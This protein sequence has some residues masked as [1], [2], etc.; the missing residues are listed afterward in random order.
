MPNKPVSQRQI[1]TRAGNKSSHPGDVLKPPKRRNTTEVEAERA[2]KAQAKKDRELARR[3]GIERTARFERDDLVRENEIDATPRPAPKQKALPRT[4]SLSSEADDAEAT[5]DGEA[6][7]K[8]SNVD[9]TISVDDSSVESGSPPPVKKVRAGSVTKGKAKATKK[10]MGKAA[11]KKVI[12]D[13][14]GRVVGPET[15]PPKPKKSLREEI[16]LI[17][18]KDEAQAKNLGTLVNLM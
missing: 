4:N 17:K 15:E 9:D 11:G 12:G 3:R 13:T 16:N 14:E 7:H 10:G 18:E 5:K 8:P 2:A 6:R 1:E